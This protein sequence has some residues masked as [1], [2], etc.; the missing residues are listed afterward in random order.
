MDILIQWIA[1]F[2][3]VV[4]VGPIGFIA[5]LAVLDFLLGSLERVDDWMTRKR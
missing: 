2:L 4:V 1:A 5:S 3:F